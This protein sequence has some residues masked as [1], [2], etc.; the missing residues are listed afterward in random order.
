MAKGSELRHE[1]QGV[2]THACEPFVVHDG[3]EWEEKCS[4]GLPF[5]LL[6]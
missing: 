4:L 3:A 2:R 5:K 1:D 6:S